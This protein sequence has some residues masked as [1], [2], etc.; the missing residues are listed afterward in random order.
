MDYP[1]HIA[2]AVRFSDDIDGHFIT[3]NGNTLISDDVVKTMHA[4]GEGVDNQLLQKL[5]QTFSSNPHFSNNSDGFIIKHYAGDV[6]YKIDG[7][8]EK[9]RDVLFQDLIDMMK[10]SS[11]FDEF[12]YNICLFEKS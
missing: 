10:N 3:Y 8:C 2:T 1:G 5:K 4:S 7:F 11:E 9:N 12:I 6:D